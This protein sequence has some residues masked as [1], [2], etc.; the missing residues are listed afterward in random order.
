MKFSKRSINKTISKIDRYFMWDSRNIGN[1]M[2]DAIDYDNH[3]YVAF[4]PFGI[5][6][7][8]SF[9]YKSSNGK[10]YY[11]VIKTYRDLNELNKLIKVMF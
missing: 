1:G 3:T 4:S 2:F 7:W 10:V 5:N 8:Y 9:Y 6:G 11:K